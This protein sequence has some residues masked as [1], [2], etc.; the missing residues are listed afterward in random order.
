ME[1]H[2]YDS[3]L[4]GW[5]TPARKFIECDKWEHLPTVF[6]TKELYRYL[7]EVLKVEITNLQEIERSCSELADEGK[8]PE[9]H[10]YECACYDANKKEMWGSL[11]DAGC[12]RVGK[13][14]DQ[15]YFEGRGQK[16]AD[17]KTALEDFADSHE[18]KAIF[19][20]V[21]KLNDQVPTNRR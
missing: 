20:R 7:P 6:S 13:F 2:N 16:L 9:W 5:M 21:E 19:E 17:L 15:I 14:A 18:C 10:V 1:R 11:L 8:H 3:D 4:F 12:I